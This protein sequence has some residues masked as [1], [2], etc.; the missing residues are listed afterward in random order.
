MLFFAYDLEEYIATRDFY[1]PFETFVPGR[2][3]RTF[4]EL[5]DA[6]RRDDYEVEKVAALRRAPLRPPRRRLDRPRHRRARSCAPMSGVVLDRPDRPGPRSAFAICRP[7]CRCGRRVVLATAHAAAR[8]AGNL[9]LHPRRARPAPPGGPGRRPRPCRPASGARAASSPPGTRCV[10]AYYLA[11]SRVFVVDDYFFPIYV[12]PAAAGHDDRPDLARLRRV[13]EG[14]LQRARQVVR[15]RRG[16]RAAGSRSTRNYDVCLV[17]VEAVAPHYAEAFRPAARAVRVPPR[18]PAH[19]RLLRRGAARP[20]A[21]RHPSPLRHAR[22]PAGRSSTPRRSAATASPTRAHADDLDLRAAARASSATTTSCSSGSTRSSASRR[23]IGPELARLRHRRLRPPRHQRADARQRRARHRLL[24]R[25]LRVRAARP[26]DRLLRARTTRPTSASAA[27]TSTTGPACPARSSRRPRASPTTSG[28]ASFDLERVDASATPSFDVADGAFH[29]T[30]LGRARPPVPSD[31]GG[32]T[33]DRAAATGRLEG[34]VYHTLPVHPGASRPCHR[35][36]PT[37]DLQSQARRQARPAP[38]LG[39]PGPTELLPQHRLR[40]RRPGRGRHPRHRRGRCTWYNDH[41]A[42]VGSVDGQSITK[43]EFARPLRRS[44]PGGSTRRSAGSAP[45]VAGRPPDRGRGASQP[46][47]R[48]AGAARLAGDHA[49]APDRQP[50][51]QAKL[52]DRGG[53]HRHAGRH[54]RPAAQGG[55]DARSRATPGSSRSQPETDAGAVE[56][57]RRPEGGRQG[58]GR[59]RAQGPPGRQGLGGRRQDRLD[60]HLDRAA[61]AATSA[62]SRPTT[63]QTRRGVPQGASS[64]P[65]STRRPRSSRAPTAIYRIGRVTEIAAETVDDAYQS[66]LTERRDRPRQVPRGRPRRRHPPEARGQDRRRRHRARA[67]ARTSRRSTSRRPPSTCRRRRDQGPPHPVLA[68]GRPAAARPRSI[69][70]RPRLE[71]RRG[72]G[73]RDLRASSRPNPSL[74]DSIARDGERRDRRPGRDRHRRQAAV[75]RHA[76]ARS[77][78]RSQAA[79]LKP[80]LKAGDLLAPVKSA[81]GWHVIQVMYRAAGPR[82]AERAQD[83]GRRRRRLR[84]ARPRQLR[85]ARR[86]ARAA[87]SAGSPRASSTRALIDG[88]LR[89]ADRQDVE[90]HRPCDDDGHLPVQGA[91]RGDADAGGP[92]ARRRSRRPRSPNWYTPKKDAADDHARSDRSRARPARREAPVLD[93]LVAEARLR[94]G[95]DPADGSPGRGRPS[96]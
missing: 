9:A 62:G 91:R 51:L 94:W 28:P 17:V 70:D 88:D 92:A 52:A 6:I 22:R 37:H 58:E 23:R 95:L 41:L 46:D 85:G 60:G 63:R 18:H 83:Q 16:A 72:R 59:R 64:R 38:V 31:P 56:P 40:H 96:G 35:N 53:H 66:K 55:D 12:D 2:I 27:S 14:R 84:R 68:Q 50:K 8:C 93:A 65:R 79:I 30:R 71:G 45:T 1:V 29:S 61:G 13:Q 49:R 43:D 90:R 32:R 7:A 77:T 26:A 57:D 76:R 10:A 75:L 44:R 34:A 89:H 87:T 4:P 20:D 86:P 69:A 33:I 5:L 80:G 73:R 24:E 67:A 19:R 21:R 42:S 54:R 15:G 3:V 36:P 82:P 78:R 74:F 47:H 81:F 39:E 48:P 11:T 25:D